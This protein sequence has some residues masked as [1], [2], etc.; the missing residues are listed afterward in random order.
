M[1]NTNSK[2][3]NEIQEETLSQKI[4]NEIIEE[5]T[6]NSEIESTGDEVKTEE[7]RPVI[8]LVFDCARLNVRKKPKLSAEVI[9]EIPLNSKVE[10]DESKSTDD[11][12]KVCTEA[13]IE[14]FCM[15][16]FVTIS[17]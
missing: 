16:K 10:I 2:K 7:K 5:A 6:V 9:A 11:W 4:E 1:S 3:T 15:K 12:F 17:K 13:G 8:G 14:G